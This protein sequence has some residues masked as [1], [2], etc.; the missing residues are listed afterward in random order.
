MNQESA[1]TDISQ[2]KLGEWNMSDERAF[3]E[4]LFV[5]RFNSFLVVFSLFVTAGFVNN[6]T[7]LRSFVFFAGALILVVVWLSLYRAYV[8][9]DRIIKLLS[10]MTDH[11]ISQINELLEHEG[12][13]T[14]SYRASFVMGVVTPA[15]CVAAL[16][17]AGCAIELGFLTKA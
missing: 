12:K 16:I 5:S 6:F 2:V 7:T 9:Y 10:G 8:K 17:I 14:K 11:P 13:N 1:K 15:L 4:N 3:M